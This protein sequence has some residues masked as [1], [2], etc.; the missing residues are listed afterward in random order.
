MNDVGPRCAQKRVRCSAALLFHQF[1]HPIVS[2]ISPPG[3]KGIQ[4]GF[5]ET[6][7]DQ[8]FMDRENRRIDKLLEKVRG[9]TQLLVVEKAYIDTV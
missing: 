9:K 1:L 3:S 8:D 7:E 2:N 4:A 5:V 6:R